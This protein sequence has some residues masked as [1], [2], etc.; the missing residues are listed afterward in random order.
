M[1]VIPAVY[2]MYMFISLYLTCF[3]L[4]LY[5][6]NKKD[7]FSYPKP[8]KKYSLSI[9]IPCYNEEKNIRTTLERF[10]LSNYP[11]LKKIIVVDDCSKD[12]SYNIVKEFA[13]KHKKI[14]LVRTP[15]NTGKASGAKNYGAKFVTTE[16]IGFTDSDSYPE[17]DTLGKMIG[18]FDDEKVGA[19]TCAILVK[20]AGKFFEKLQAIEYSI[21][22]WT[23]KLLGYVGAIWVTPGPLAIYRKSVLDK[24]GYFDESNLTEDIEMTWRITYFGY[25]RESNIDARVYT[26]VPDRLKE[27]WKQRIR[28]NIGGLQTISKYKSFFFKKGMLGLFIIPFFVISMTLGLLGL[29][30]F[31]YLLSKRIYYAFF[32]TSYSLKAQ[33]SVL[34]VEDLYLTPSVLNY[35]GIALFLSGLVFTIFG[36]RIMKKQRVRNIKF[37]DILFYM[38]VYLTIYPLIFTFASYNFIRG[39]RNWGTRGL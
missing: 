38:V 30:I 6:K 2:L 33:T 32:Y 25:K 20:D 12:N 3:F 11:G 16:L 37:W 36:M 23:R 21:I 35:Y 17:E 31:L 15:K 19:V 24:I 27:W 4:I 34:V 26:A 22:S 8:K 5:F 7:L 9:V 14:L 10:L 13:D 18:Y 39:K 29:F 28:W 1:E